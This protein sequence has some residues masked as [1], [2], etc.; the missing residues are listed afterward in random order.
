MAHPEN[1]SRR[2]RKKSWLGRILIW[3]AGMVV[4]LL[5]A[6]VIATPWILRSA[7]P[8]AFARYSMQA[9]ARGGSLS[10][11]RRELTLQGFILGAPDAPALSLGELG[12]GLDLR[13]LFKGRIKLRHLRVKDVSVNARRLLA[14]RKSDGEGAVSRKGGL[15]VELGELA[16]EDIRLI[17][18][19]ERIGH[20]VRIGR[21][22]LNDV[23]A[24][25]DGRNSS[26]DLQ[27]AI[28]DGSVNLQLDVGLDGEKL[29][30]AGKY[31]V[32]KVPVVGWAGSG[33]EKSD[34]LSQGVVDGRGDIHVDYAFEAKS[35]GAILDGRVSLTGLGVE[36]APL[37]AEGGEANWQGRL[38]LQWSPDLTAPK[39]RGDGSLDVDTLQLTLSH[40]SRAPIHAAISDISWHGDFDW[41][42]GFTSEGA[43]LGTRVEV[44]DA[45][46]ATPAWRS[47]AEDFSWRLHARVEDNS[48]KFAVRVQD[49]DLARFTVSSNDADAPVGIA[50]EKLAVDEMRSAQS[51]DLVLGQATVDTL[52][53]T[54]SG[55]ANNAEAAT[56]R[57][58]GLSAKGMSGDFS[59]KLHA[60]QVSAESLDYAQSAR[61]LR[62][63]EI[64]FAS[65]G[66]SAP[67]WL[68]AGELKVKSVRAGEGQGDIWVSGLKLGKVHG[69]ADGSFGAESVDVTHMF[70]SGSNELSWETSG[71]KLRAIKGDIKDAAHVSAID[72]GALKIG[73]GETS[74]ESSGMR[75]T[76]VV[77]GMNGNLDV[78]SLALATLE[79]RQPSA[80]NLHVAELGAH[81]LRIRDAGAVLD[82]VK[83][84]RLA[85]NLPDGDTIETHALEARQLS[86][87]LSTGLE[88][89]RLSVAGGTGRLVSGARVSAAMLESRGLSVA[90]NGGVALE[91]AQLGK[92]SFTGSD[93]AVLDLDGLGIA[94]LSWAPDG[95]LSSARAA[96]H[97]AR[98]AR[99]D[100]VSWS[101]AVLDAG[102]L[103]WDGDAA[104][105]A[106]S[107][108]LASVSQNRGESRDWRA[109]VLRATG[110]HLALPGDVAVATLSAESV[111]GGSGSPAWELT[112]VDARGL[113][114][115]EDHGQK[116]ALFASGAV[117]VTDKGNG[118]ALSLRRAEIAAFKVDKLEQLSAEQLLVDGLRLG[119]DK[120]D[121]PSRLT[122]AELRI[123]KPRL[124][125]DG[126][127]HLGDVLAR[128]PYLI[129]A[130]SEDN[131]WMWPPLPG[132][133]GQEDS[134]G[135][136][137]ES[138]KLGISIES[139]TTRGPGRIA[140]IDRATEPAIH[141]ILDPVVVAIE[142]IDT[143]LPGN[144]SRFR[145]RGTSSR[146]AG[147]SLQGEL[148][149]R[150]EHFDMQL[151]VTVKGAD[152]PAF[153]PYIARHEAVAAT[154]GRVDG[155]NDIAI[156]NDELSGQVDLLLSGLE[157]RSTSGSKA[158]EKID[159]ANFPIR[160]ALALLKDRQGNIS[161][162][163]PLQAQRQGS[164]YDFVDDFQKD[165]V[166]T[167]TTAGQVAA[168]LSGKTLDSA[169]QLL[170][171]TI[172][173]L[174]GISAERYAPVAFAH[175]EDDLTAT[176][177]VYLDQLG[178]RM[179]DH[180]SLE[181]ALC[182]RAVSDDGEALTEQ[183]SSIGALI[184]EASKGVFPIYAPGPDGL[185]A[186]AEARAEI[187][188]RYL[189]DVHKISEQRLSACEAQI[190]E[191]AGAKPRV[192]LQVKVAAKR[193][194]LF[195][196][197]P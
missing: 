96:L 30:A 146:F 86:G 116:L 67:A 191:A 132:G 57:I 158:F 177:L 20:D 62:A 37:E 138:S 14:L 164:K 38:A 8:E 71:L 59:G 109:R 63:D 160:T 137:R 140:Y 60:A 126:M 175:G 107:A 128:N 162:S 17:S 89:G 121:W 167:V 2:R 87:D 187:V 28:G 110:F 153:N 142:N 95:G 7:V 72:L 131:N 168:N 171:R 184:A 22:E 155:Y 41:R 90:T 178:K 64:D 101:L 27:G 129:V 46:S 69:D 32:D 196:I 23:S 84:A 51:G 26:V 68:G 188:R 58:G 149:K 123:G 163:I 181:L 139:F 179:A 103:H 65:V 33:P 135:D 79:R 156:E 56:Y 10:L 115:S 34:P 93:A 102:N 141:L 120:P 125:F 15:P 39:L 43:V 145:A 82:G 150:I 176:P 99:A 76:D 159:P 1:R 143:R 182:G 148:R 161:L 111:D 44:A 117:T 77:L 42:D 170:E 147:L 74:W 21:L 130:Q 45:S 29:K 113:S 118:A 50:V 154:A 124:G 36:M 194:G 190:E 55:G 157:L 122:V 151:K 3:C 173:L 97:A 166:R 78:A 31:H 98:F 94:A 119:S 192:D 195:G 133:N 80:G 88:S 183:T 11:L 48:G 5:V 197:F 13:A 180:E 85:Y 53:V 75:G 47:H 172:S 165:F 70:Q 66:F 6:L 91:Q 193:R 16:L 186:L 100:G 24:L 12:I 25:L 19:G 61:H 174:P 18:L 73:I 40:S 83:A 4:V 136:G 52:T 189:R 54:E 104:I 114:S 112:S 108:A 81:G 134:K 144:L 152:L 105:N 169:L 49:F 106:D 127:V 9:S 92:F 35:F 185:L